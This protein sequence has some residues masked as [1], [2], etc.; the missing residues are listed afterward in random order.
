MT[1][2]QVLTQE[3]HHGRM[4]DAG[5]PGDTPESVDRPH[6]DVGLV[7]FP[8][9]LNRFGQTIRDLTFTRQPYGPPGKR[10]SHDQ[11]QRAHQLDTDRPDVITSL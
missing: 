10:T 6:A 2:A 7:V 3:R 8:E 1:C 4:V 11:R 5:V 9:L